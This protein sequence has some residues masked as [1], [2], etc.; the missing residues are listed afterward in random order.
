MK[1]AFLMLFMYAFWFS[2]FGSIGWL[3][4]SVKKWDKMQQKKQRDYQRSK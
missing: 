4:F 1:Q 3:V 2:V